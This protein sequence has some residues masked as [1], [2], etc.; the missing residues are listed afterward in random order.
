MPLR[1][2]LA[3]TVAVLALG[4]LSGCAA[5]RT[6][7]PSLAAVEPGHG[8]K[9]V[10]YLNNTL[11]FRA[12]AN[13]M[14]QPGSRP[15]VVTV[16]SGPAV[17][18]IWRY[19]RSPSQPLPIDSTQLEQARASLLGAAAARDG[20]FRVISSAV[21]VLHGVPGVELDALETIRGHVRRVRSTHLYQGGAELVVDEYA[22][23][24]VFHAVDR[25]VFSPLLHS[26][27]LV[28]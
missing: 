7:A 3:A 25:M 5:S 19:S 1:R 9:T 10:D 24:D 21:V 11:Q 15:L 12:P 13:W 17:V 22:P 20:T 2:P 16:G 8:L 27:H 14:T 23:E 6:P 28:G 18:A 26:V 4:A